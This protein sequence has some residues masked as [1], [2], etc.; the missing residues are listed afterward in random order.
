M[1]VQILRLILTSLFVFLLLG[2]T[3]SDAV[4]PTDIS[5]QSNDN[6][7][8]DLSEVSGEVKEVFERLSGWDIEELD[9][10][11]C[12]DKYSSRITSGETNAWI[13]RHE[14]ELKEFGF[15]AK[16]NCDT[17]IYELFEIEL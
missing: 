10:A 4:K 15:I 8:V 3:R 16:W 1:H 9:I 6:T 5:G 14:E 7:A 2:C 13:S 12:P 17:R 11:E